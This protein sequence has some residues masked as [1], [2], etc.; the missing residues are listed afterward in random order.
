M[1]RQRILRWS[2]FLAVALSLAACAKL[3][4][5]VTPNTDLNRYE[6]YFV[7]RHAKDIRLIDEII[8]DEMVLLGLKTDSGTIGQKPPNVDVIVTYE[9]RWAWDMTTYMLSLTIDFRDARNN[10][11]LATGQSYRPSLE[12]KPPQEMAR[13]VLQSI[14]QKAEK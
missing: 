14:M 6:T 12:R 2:V 1:K 13:E 8:R 7:V 3:S 4:S 9:D 11:L 10:V 5:R